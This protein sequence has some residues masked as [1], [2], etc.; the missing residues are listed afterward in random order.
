MVTRD[1]MLHI[2]FEKTGGRCYHCAKKLSF[3]NYG[4]IDG[5]GS[6]EIDHSTPRA[7]GGTDY[8]RNLFPSCIKCNRSKGA[9]NSDK[10]GS[11]KHLSD[12][13]SKPLIHPKKKLNN[14][15]L[16]E[17]EK[18]S[19]KDKAR[20]WREFRQRWPGTWRELKRVLDL[21]S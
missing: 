17:I 21:R 9:L 15:N 8:L 20:F 14:V 19:P 12:A 6:W 7:E 5:H 1:D 2:I 10:F 18:L 4:T 13:M 16:R 3:S 11:A